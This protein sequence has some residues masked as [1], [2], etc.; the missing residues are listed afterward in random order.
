[1]ILKND[2][3]ILYWMWKFGLLRTYVHM[4]CARL[5]PRRGVR[6]VYNWMLRRQVR[7]GLHHAPR[8]SGK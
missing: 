6:W 5:R 1:M 3:R 8:V 4:R 2:R 7:D